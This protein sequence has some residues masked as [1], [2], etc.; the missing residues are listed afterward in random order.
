MD[1]NL[2]DTQ[3]SIRSLKATVRKDVAH[4]SRLPEELLAHIFLEY[5][6][7]SDFGMYQCKSYKCLRILICVCRRWKKTTED[8]PQIWS[9]LNSWAPFSWMG[10]SFDRS[11]SA[12]LDILFWDTADTPECNACVAK[13]LSNSSRLARVSITNRTSRLGRFA[14]PLTPSAPLLHDLD[15]ASTDVGDNGVAFAQLPTNLFSNDTPR[16]Q[17]LVLEN[18]ILPWSS[19]LYSALISLSITMWEWAPGHVIWNKPQPSPQQLSQVAIL[20]RLETLVLSGATAQVAQWLARMSY[21]SSAKTRLSCQGIEDAG[22]ALLASTVSSFT[23][24]SAAD[25]VQNP[26]KSLWISL[27][28]EGILD[29]PEAFTLCLSGWAVVVDIADLRFCHDG[30]GDALDLLSISIRLPRGVEAPSPHLLFPIIPM[31]DVEVVGMSYDFPAGDAIRGVV[32]SPI[33]Q[34][35]A[36]APSLHTLRIRHLGQRNFIKSL[37]ADPAF[38]TLS[39]PES[40]ITFFPKLQHLAIREV[41]FDGESDEIGNLARAL[42]LRSS[43]GTRLQ[44]LTLSKCFVHDV[45][46]LREVV[47][48]FE[49]E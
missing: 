12:P 35:L 1:E 2:E 41:Y 32:T 43:R 26:L 19:R 8:C 28:S 40:P 45:G 30:P 18:C 11:K 10:K 38:D 42:Q 7:L 48:V 25:Q 20:P 37:L 13:A 31:R 39:E 15:L 22:V 17:V 3:I 5:V 9:K 16:L 4:I 36:T 27:E 14:A 49:M 21:P 46:R 47:D 6:N 33:D 34:L 44:R 29:P 24:K 23:L